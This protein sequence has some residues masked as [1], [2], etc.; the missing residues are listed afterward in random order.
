M[1][2]PPPHFYGKQRVQRL[3]VFAFSV[4]NSNNEHINLGSKGSLWVKFEGGKFA[5]AELCL[6]IWL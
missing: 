3:H 6:K 1:H 4:I 5:F 2:A